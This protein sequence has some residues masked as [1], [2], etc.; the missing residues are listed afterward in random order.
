MYSGHD[1]RLLTQSEITLGFY[2]I[3]ISWWSMLESW[4][5]R[6]AH[7]DELTPTWIVFFPKQLIEGLGVL[8]L[9]FSNTKTF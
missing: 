3:R 5:Q 1:Y 4:I 9:E 2:L 6:F 8:G 7:C